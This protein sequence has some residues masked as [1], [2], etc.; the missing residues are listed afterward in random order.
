M[1]IIVLRKQFV[2]D[3]PTASET[4]ETTSDAEPEQTSEPEP[5]FLHIILSAGLIETDEL[6]ELLQVVEK[7]VHAG[8]VE[9]IILSGRL[10]AW[11]FS[12]LTHHFHPRPW[13]AT[14]DPRHQAAVVTATHS[15]KV[16]RGQLIPVDKGS[17]E[18]VEI[19]FPP[20]PKPATPAEEG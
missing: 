4:E 3:T 18:V 8:G 5:I 13:I 16:R 2:E 7:H 10:P 1:R 19:T 20:M 17:V 14:F 11:V 12:A 15:T 9:P 6:E